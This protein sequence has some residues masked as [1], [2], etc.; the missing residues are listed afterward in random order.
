MSRGGQ[1][2]YS[3]QYPLRRASSWRDKLLVVIVIRST[4]LNTLSVGHPL[5]GGDTAIEQ[6]DVLKSQYP[7][8][9]AS[10]CRILQSKARWRYLLV[11]IP[12]QSGILLAVVGR[13]TQ[14]AQRVRSQYPH[15]RASSCRE[16]GESMAAKYTGLNTLTVGHPLVGTTQTRTRH[17]HMLSIPSQS[18]SLLSAGLTLKGDASSQ[19]PH[20]RAASCR[21]TGDGS[22]TDRL[23]TLTG[24]HPLGGRLAPQDQ[25]EHCACLN[26]LTGGHPLGGLMVNPGLCRQHFVSIPSQ[27]GQ[28]LVGGRF[29]CIAAGI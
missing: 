29:G 28:P 9:R 11:S 23:N 22:V 12:S 3:S 27:V 21:F 2:W 24:G 6:T 5:G 17:A 7:L 14:N 16:G 20:S 19:Y 25:L 15:S 10:S 26:T 13:R 1:L 8:S 18:G 4:S